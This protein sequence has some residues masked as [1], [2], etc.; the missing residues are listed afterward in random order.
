MPIREVLY[1]GNVY[2]SAPIS[3]YIIWWT[4]PIWMNFRFTVVNQSE[5]DD[6]EKKSSNWWHGRWIEPKTIQ[7]VAS[8]RPRPFFC[9]RVSYLVP[10]IFINFLL[11]RLFLRLS[12]VGIEHI[13]NISARCCSAWVWVFDTG[14]SEKSSRPAC[15][16]VAR[17][18]FV[19]SYVTLTFVLSILDQEKTKRKWRWHFVTSGINTS[20]FNNLKCSRFYRF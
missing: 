7:V 4:I 18:D 11:S 1:A 16:R 2:F 15:I 5:T 8:I 6:S 19:T 20:H 14:P 17:V 10:A 12:W 9:F 13:S 3:N